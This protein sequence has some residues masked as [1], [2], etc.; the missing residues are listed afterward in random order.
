MSDQLRNLNDTLE[1]SSR[2]LNSLNSVLGMATS[3]KQALNQ[4][5]KD[6]LESQKE[7]KEKLEKFSKHV[8]DATGGIL[9][10]GKEVQSSA[11]SFAPLGDIILKTGD[12]VGGTFKA[13]LKSVPIL[14]SA[15]DA[16][17]KAAAGVAAHMVNEFEKAYS[18]FEKVSGS[19]VIDSFTMF[20]QSAG[21]MGLLFSDFDRVMTKG[22]KDLALLGGGA[23][24]GTKIMSQLGAGSEHLRMQFQKLGI[25]SAEVSEF[26][27]SYLTQQQQMNRGRTTIDR[28]LIEASGEYVKELDLVAKL[29]GLTRKE[30]D[31]N[32]RDLKNDSTIRANM[33]DMS[34]AAIKN[35]ELLNDAMISV[36]KD[37]EMANRMIKVMMSG[38]AHFDK[39][40]TTAVAQGGGDLIL[41]GKKLREGK[42]SM[43]DAGKEISGA[44]KNFADAQKNLSA[45]GVNDKLFQ[46]FPQA[47]DMFNYFNK[48][49]NKDVQD[50]IK[51]Q[52]KQSRETEGLN[53]S[54][55]TSKQK[56]YQ[57]SQK[58]EKL[59]V[60]S[61]TLA[62]T[63]KHMSNALY[64]MIDKANKAAG[65][66]NPEHVERFIELAEHQ[67]K[68]IKAQTA[69]TAMIAK[70][71]DT[72]GLAQMASPEEQTSAD[73]QIQ[74]EIENSNEA[75]RKLKI[76]EDEKRKALI[77]A[78]IDAG[79]RSALEDKD[80]NGNPRPA[81]AQSSAPIGAP[82]GQPTNTG[83]QS[84]QTT[85]NDLSGDY[86]G[87]NIRQNP[88]VN[89]VPEPVSGGQASKKAI[90]LARKI[91]G[92]IPGVMFTAFNDSYNRG[93]NSAHSH[94]RAVDF[95]LPNRPSRQQGAELVAKL[96][97]LGASGAIDE[98]NNPS[99]RA[100][101]PHMH[102]QVSAA[103]GG[104]MSGPKS[105]YLA[106]LHGEE[107]VIQPQSASKQSLNSTVSGLTGPSNRANLSDIYENLSDKMDRLVDILSE[108]HDSQIKFME[109]QES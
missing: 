33:D 89:G 102:A 75:I 63:M 8:I 81:G 69:Q 74:K 57:S 58:L 47:Q 59:S 100:T 68:I 13:L 91:Q 97:S 37:K 9:R 12:L 77:K 109:S 85:G 62:S 28:S 11:G 84:S 82:S 15:I 103:T 4:A 29:T 31:Q 64:W 24:N 61:D 46:M 90:E 108:Q 70:L 55:A 10:F 98:Y 51:N 45:I 38:Q 32:R 42:I 22:S 36:T 7:S 27:L 93:P 50:L 53:S 20:E 96:R 56:L 21:A 67:D 49:T 86:S 107:A 71:G 6:E 39:D 26:Q 95:V 44:L 94:G 17:S 101:G 78:E 73:E 104:I 25:N 87:L 48:I 52:D 3:T 105:G 80:E 34:P 1:Q 40:M 43:V 41:I 106:E 99:S 83:T 5:A 35:F 23:A 92:A 30:A 66:K 65:I 79:I 14:G 19:G 88:K 2:E 60:S 18:T 54:L 16:A 72:Y 76:Q